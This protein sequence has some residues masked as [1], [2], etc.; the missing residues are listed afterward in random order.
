MII[1]N[2]LG[3]AFFHSA[4][5]LK[6]KPRCCAHP[7]PLLLSAEW[8]P[9][10]YVYSRLFNHSPGEGHL[11]C[12]QV[13][14][15]SSTPA[16]NN[17]ACPGFCVNGSFSFSGINVRI[18]IARSDGMWNCQ[19]AFQSGYDIS[20]VRHECRSNPVSLHLHQ[21]SV[22]SFFSRSKTYVVTSHCGLNGDY[23]SD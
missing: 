5:T 6:I 7:Q 4:L 18:G 2:F 14:A 19:T 13:V 15:L 3:L 1:S 16:K 9:V 20:H 21:H 8:H 10:S 11:G 23:P 17:H 22:L 12:S